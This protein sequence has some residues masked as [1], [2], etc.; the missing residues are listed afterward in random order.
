MKPRPYIGGLAIILGI[1]AFAAC[2]GSSN[3]GQ[4]TP[5][6]PAAVVTVSVTPKP[7]PKPTAAPKASLT[8]VVRDIST[9]AVL[10]GFTITLGAVPVA[11]TCLTA[12]TAS[13]MPCGVP[14]SPLITKATSASGSFDITL[15]TQGKY[16]LTI[17]KNGTYAK[18]HRTITLS[19]GVNPLGTVYLTALDA[20]HQAWLADF[21]NRRLTVSSPASLPNLVID[22]YAE[23]QAEA[24]VAGEQGA[25]STTVSDAAFETAY[26][27]ST[28]ALYTATGYNFGV[29]SDGEANAIN[30]VDITGFNFDQQ[31]C[32]PNWLTCTP[33]GAPALHTD[34]PGFS[35][36]RDVWVGLGFP[37]ESTGDARYYFAVM[38]VANPSGTAPTEIFRQ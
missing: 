25:D 33:A 10:S 30:A 1:C 9:H 15:I 19:A 12:Q 23:E 2:S 16:L 31:Y 22:E 21:N 11:T 18:L 13:T 29:S 27:A 8:G 37:T 24:A 6:L 4:A 17:G 36:K 3:V 34:Y 14:V 7:T 35:S 38:V 28:G 26:A 32:T 20:P 5:N